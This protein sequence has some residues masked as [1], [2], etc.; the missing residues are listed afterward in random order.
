MLEMFANLPFELQRTIADMLTCED[1]LKLNLSEEHTAELLGRSHESWLMKRVSKSDDIIIKITDSTGFALVN[2]RRLDAFDDSSLQLYP[3]GLDSGW[4]K[5]NFNCTG[6]DIVRIGYPHLS[7]EYNE[8]YP[9]DNTVNFDQLQS[10]FEESDFRVQVEDANH[11]NIKSCTTHMKP[12]RPFG[13][14]P[15][16]ESAVFYILFD[17]Y[18][19]N[20]TLELVHPTNNLK[21]TCNRFKCG[22]CS[23]SKVYLILDNL[24][25]K[26]YKIVINVLWLTNSSLSTDSFHIV[27]YDYKD[28]SNVGYAILDGD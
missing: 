7:K 12:L 17:Q 8:C 20:Y 21:C 3:T 4:Y 9:F 16:K 11:W 1:I 5:L 13:D 25:V 24:I 14:A 15:G 6:V 2:H 19:H 22:Y 18:S 10:L 23:S 28:Q 26:G 27:R